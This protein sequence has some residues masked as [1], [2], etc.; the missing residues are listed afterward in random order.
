MSNIPSSDD[1]KKFRDFKQELQLFAQQENSKE[2]TFGLILNSKITSQRLYPSPLRSEFTGHFKSS[3]KVEFNPANESYFLT[4]GEDGFINI[5]HYGEASILLMLEIQSGTIA[6]VSWLISNPNSILVA[7]KEGLLQIYDLADS[8]DIPNESIEV[9]L[10]ETDE[11]ASIS[12][13]DSQGMI[14][15]VSRLG[16]LSCFEIEVQGNGNE[17]LLDR[18]YPA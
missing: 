9:I 1:K 13:G 2:I 11:I 17:F 15:V 18:I 8:I 12:I 14:A 16:E 6:D 5:Y 4:Y 3:K 10:K 7:T